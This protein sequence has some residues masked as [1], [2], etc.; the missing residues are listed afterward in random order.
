MELC[1][2]DVREFLEQPPRRTM[3]ARVVCLLGIAPEK[4]LRGKKRTEGS[5]SATVFSMAGSS[6]RSGDIPHCQLLRGS[7]A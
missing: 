7:G 4:C 1:P 3:D 5:N 2:F 6:T